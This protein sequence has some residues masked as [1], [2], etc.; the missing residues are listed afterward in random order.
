MNRRMK[1]AKQRGGIFDFE[2][3]DAHG[4]W[5]AGEGSV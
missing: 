5:G 2:F 3:T 4:K 1:Y